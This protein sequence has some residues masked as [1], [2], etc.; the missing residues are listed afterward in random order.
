MSVFQRKAR[1]GSRFRLTVAQDRPDNG[2]WRAVKAAVGRHSDHRRTPQCEAWPNIPGI[3]ALGNILTV[4]SDPADATT[5]SG[6]EGDHFLSAD[7]SCV[8][9]ASSKADIAVRA[10]SSPQSR[11]YSLQPSRFF[12]SHA[13]SSAVRAFAAPG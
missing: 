4:V 6:G 10:R 12:S 8:M 11:E 7:S 9:S 1:T 2:H 13:R 3:T 5:P